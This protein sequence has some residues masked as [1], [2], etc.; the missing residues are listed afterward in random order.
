[1]IE[2][3]L[4]WLVLFKISNIQQRR[5]WAD[6]ADGEVIP[7]ASLIHSILSGKLCYY[8]WQNKWPAPMGAAEGP[9]KRPHPL[10]KAWMNTWGDSLG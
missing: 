9:L 2:A 8:Y 6:A 1:M 4:V 5:R 3:I 7:M 10:G